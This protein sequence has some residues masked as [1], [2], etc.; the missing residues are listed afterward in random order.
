MKTYKRAERVAPLVREI[1]S[2]L[3][4]NR[5]KDPRI[6]AAIITRIEMKDDL[7][8]ARIYYRVGPRGNRE[9]VSAGFE[10]A[11]GFLRRELGTQLQMKFV[12]DLRFQYDDSPEAIAR[13]EEILRGL[14]TEPK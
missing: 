11:K 5:V 7:R 12:P 1:L 9:D 4:R 2:D 3:I 13:V 14:E 10:Q 8:L 6:H